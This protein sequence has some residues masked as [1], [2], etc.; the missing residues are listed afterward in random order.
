MTYDNT[1][2]NDDGT[3]EA[4]IDNQS[5]STEQLNTRIRFVDQ[6]ATA[7]SGTSSDPWVNGFNAAMNSVPNDELPVLI[8]PP[9][10]Y[11]ITETIELKQGIRSRST[12]SFSG[13]E[14]SKW[15]IP[16]IVGCGKFS[17][18]LYLADSADTD[19]FELDVSADMADG[20]NTVGGGLFGLTAN[21]NADNN[22]SGS[23]LNVIDN[24]VG[25]SFTHFTID[26][27]Y[28]RMS[29]DA[30]I[31]DS[32]RH[33][34]ESVVSDTTIN[35]A[36]TTLV[37]GLAGRNRF[38]NTRFN[39]AINGAGVEV[40][41]NNN[42]F[43]N[44]EFR[45]NEEHG[46]INDVAAEGTVVSDSVFLNNSSDA[47]VP[48]IFS[49]GDNARFSGYIDADGNSS[50][51]IRDS[52][53]TDSDYGGL[54]IIGASDKIDFIA[55]DRPRYNGIIGG[56]FIGGVDLGSVTGQYVGDAALADGTTGTAYLN[57]VWNGSQWVQSDGTTV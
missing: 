5:V 2:N 35:R 52:A 19:M 51:A 1:D 26:K 53:A 33:I 37:T 4:D 45:G 44:C 49:E 3:V 54:T 23:V 24:G 8:A 39:F 7:G 50:A 30:I 12:L 56:G 6:Y 41:G 13:G 11:E 16:P 20:D 15:V 31:E 18:S 22:A 28:L 17:T 42:V 48:Q 9:G 32:G 36:R 55:V 47:S 34:G 38:V 21:G 57:A 10:E 14:F 46:L 40:F 43:D 25:S 29:Q 27:C